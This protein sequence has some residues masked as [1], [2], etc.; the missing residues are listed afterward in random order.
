MRYW[1]AILIIISFSAC[2]TKWYHP[3]KGEAE[4]AKDKAEC[5]AIAKFAGLNASYNGKR[6]EPNAYYEA[7]NRCLAQ[8]GWSLTPAQTKNTGKTPAPKVLAKQVKSNTFNFEGKTVVLPPGTKLTSHTF[9]SY[10]LIFMENLEFEGRINELPYDGQIIFQEA[11]GASKFKSI[12]Y[13]LTRPFFTYSLGQL[14]NGL[15]WHSFAGKL[16]NKEWYGGIGCYLRISR[17]KR[18]IITLTTPLPAQ[19][20]PPPPRCRLNDAQAETLDNFLNAILPWFKT[21][22]KKKKWP[23][24]KRERFRFQ[25]PD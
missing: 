17:K 20:I 1:L 6:I 15:R 18:V 16:N 19:D 12:I 25:L 24:F 8:K 7:L 9:T 21:L 14:S 11:L 3:T 4:F 2:S 13:P 10:G 23:S 5:E 22:E